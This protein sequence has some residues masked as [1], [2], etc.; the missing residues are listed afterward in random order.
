YCCFDIM[1]KILWVGLIALTLSGCG[2][3]AEKTVNTGVDTLNEAIR[4]L[5]SNSNRWQEVLKDTQNT[6]ITEGQSTLANEV[7]SVIS[8]ATSD[9]GMEAKCSVDFLRD[10]AREDLIRLRA[11]ITKE[12]LDLTPVFCNPTPNAVDLNLPPNRRPLVEIAGYNLTR[13][14]IDVFL[15]DTQGRKLEVSDSLDNPSQYLLTVTLDRIPLNEESKRLIFELANGEQQTVGIIQAYKPPKIEYRTSRI[16]ITG[17]I[18]LNDKEWISDEN[19]SIS[20][21]TYVDVP[22]SRNTPYSWDGCVGDEVHGYLNVKMQLNPNTG[23]VSGQGLGQYYEGTKCGRTQ[24]HGEETFDFSLPVN[25]NHLFQRTLTDN[26]G[27]V[28][29]NLSFEHISAQTQCVENC[30]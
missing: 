5:E 16:R 11:T 13:D 28:T 17:T 19:R 29:Y 6:L 3:S 8:R 12:T 26:D 10:R 14:A 7:S 27:G 2:F 23:V 20:I 22:S 9:V 30:L 1:K 25:K 18:N 15:E 4:K 21:N 24:L